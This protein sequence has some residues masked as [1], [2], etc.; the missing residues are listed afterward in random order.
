[1]GDIH[2][3]RKIGLLGSVIA[4]IG[5]V[6]NG[7]F[8]HIPS[9]WN[10]ISPVPLVACTL[11]LISLWGI[12]NKTGDSR[13]FRNYLTSFAVWVVFNIMATAVF[14]AGVHSAVINSHMKTNSINLSDIDDPHLRMFL[15]LAILLVLIGLS[16]SSYFEMRT[17]KA[18]HEISGI[19]EFDNAAT[20]FKWGAATMVVFIGFLFVF[21]ARIFV[22]MAF[23]G[24]P[25]SLERKRTDAPASP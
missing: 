11:I 18:M 6:I 4:L 8:M 1:M 16:V 7:V 12:G 21:I 24:L 20:W 9:I 14:S 2:I 23:N 15:I 25:E 17:W 5:G 13:P 22:I 19:R 10:A 3:E